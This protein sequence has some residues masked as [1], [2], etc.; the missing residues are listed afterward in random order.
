MMPAISPGRTARAGD[1]HR[2]LRAA[3]TLLQLF[4]QRRSR[5]SY[6]AAVVA[7]LARLTGCRR[8]G[9]RVLNP[10]NEIPYEATRGFNRAFL[11]SECW[12]SL[13]RDNCICPRIMRRAPTPPEAA[14]L[15]RRGAFAAN[16]AAAFMRALSP[17][18]RRQYRGTCVAAGFSSVA[19]VPLLYQGR[20]VGAIHLADRRPGR[21]GAEV[22]RFV[23]SIAPLIGEAIHRF[24]VEDELRE[25]NAALE[26][27]FSN[28]HIQ[29]A[30]LDRGLCYVRVNDA[31]ARAGGHPPAWY[32]GRRHFDLFPDRNAKALFRKV[33]RTGK[34]LQLVERP[35]LLRRKPERAPTYWDWILAPVRGEGA[36]VESLVVA[37]IDRTDRVRSR[38]AQAESHRLLRAI[39]DEAF[40]FMDSWIPPAPCSRSTAPPWI[41]SGARP[42]RRLGVRC[43]NCR[44]GPGRRRSASACAPPW[45]RPPRAALCATRRRS[46]G[47]AVA[48]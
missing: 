39:F 27:M 32:R 29:F 47:P 4:V 12:L 28:I 19:V 45:P 24:N 42:R 22:I 9:V 20:I 26:R 44:R 34:P 2:Y 46:T 17:R 43:G 35:S 13:T 38:L 8:L 5:K 41:L 30:C 15:T 25:S 3:Y 40:Q 14:L 36:R 6:L 31:F 16:D 33:L 11:R 1:T 23:E 37:L 18:E 10:R 21:V 7:E 48:R